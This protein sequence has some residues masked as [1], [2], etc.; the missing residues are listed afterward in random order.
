MCEGRRP[1]SLTEWAED[2]CQDILVLG[3]DEASREVMDPI[4]QAIFQRAVEVALAR[5]EATPHE[6]DQGENQTLFMLDEVR[7]AG[8]LD[9]LGR[10]LNKGRSKNCVAILG[11]Q[12]IE[13]MV[14]VYGQNVAHELCG[15]CAHLAVLKL[16][17]GQTAEWGVDLFGHRLTTDISGTHGTD[18]EG[19]MNR[20]MQAGEN[21]RSW[22]NTDDFLYLPEAGP[23]H[24]LWG[25]VRTPEV[26]PEQHD[27]WMHLSWSEVLALQPPVPDGTGWRAPHLRRPEGEMYLRPWDE[28]DWARLGFPG[29][30]PPWT[31]PPKQDEPSP[32][33]PSPSGPSSPTP[34]PRAFP[35][36]RPIV[37][38]DF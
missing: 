15:Q 30:P 16:N 10:L 5:R 33:D 31:G 11:F 2:G 14:D 38:A 28:D 25:Y 23:K 22:L 32:S 21:V 13:G 7:E 1:F 17:S 6:R 20:S 24:G 19:R 27:L 37:V 18:T 26:D 35:G 12:S 3:N 36:L 29:E 34:A 8:P 9:G 4:N